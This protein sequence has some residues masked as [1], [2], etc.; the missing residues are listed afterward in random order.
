MSKIS[1]LLNKDFIFGIMDNMTIISAKILYGREVNLLIVD[2]EFWYP[3]N[4]VLCHC[5]TRDA[6]LVLDIGNTL[7]AEV[8]ST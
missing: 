4:Q 6:E 8:F 1:S 3:I 5:K 2:I 7:E